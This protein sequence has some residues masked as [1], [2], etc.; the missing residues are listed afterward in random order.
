M[1]RN[2]DWQP[3]ENTPPTLDLPEDKTVEATGPNGA[4]VTY[5]ATA[6]DLVGG[7]VS[8]NCIPASGGTFALGDRT[9]NCS[10]EDAAGNEA[11]GSFKVTVE[12]SNAPSLTVPSDTIV[13]EAACAS[14]PRLTSRTMSRRKI[15]SPAGWGSSG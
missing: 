6:T 13:V 1:A 2:P 7:N 5:F 10:A 12:G 8:V 9:V 3:L 15:L 11:K 4:E 14:V